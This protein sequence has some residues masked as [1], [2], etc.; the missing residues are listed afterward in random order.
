MPSDGDANS[1]AT[2]SATAPSGSIMASSFMCNV[3]LPP[4]LEIHSGKLSKEWKQWRQ[5][6]DAYE[7]VTDLRAAFALQRLSPALVKK[8]SKFIMVYLL[9][10]K[11]RN[12]T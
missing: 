9:E 10:V 12:P 3:S 5:V 1:G 2:A 7:E 8:P 6:W 4:K 11:R